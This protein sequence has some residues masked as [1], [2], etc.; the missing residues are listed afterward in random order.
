MKQVKIFFVCFLAIIGTFGMM[1]ATVWAAEK[2]RVVTIKD[3]KDSKEFYDDP[4]PWLTS[5]AF[6]YKKILPPD[7]HAKLSYDVEAMKTLW[8][9]VIGFKAP[10]V[11]HKIA[12]QIK[13]G[14]YSYKD[15]EQHPG[16]KAL[17]TEYHYNRFKP[18]APPFAGNFP[19]M[20][21]V[22]TKQY[23]YA[24]PIA[25]ATKKHM[26]QTMLDNQ[27]GLINEATY[28]AGLP[29]PRPEGKLKANQIYYNWLKRYFGWDNRYMLSEVRG[30]TGSLR[31]DISQGFLMWTLRLQGRVLEPYGWL[32]ERAQ[33][34]GEFQAYLSRYFAPRD[35]FG[36][37][38]N[39]ITYMAPDKYDQ[40]M[41]YVA[42]LRR[43][44]LMSSTDVQDAVAGGDAIYLDSD[45]CAQK[46]SQTIFPTKLELIAEKE[47]LF[48]TNH[49]GSAYLTSPD[50][51]LEYHNLKWER[52]PIYVIKMTIHD[53]N[54]V[55]GH[56]ILYI[57]KETFL[58]RLAENY[59]QNGRL[60]RTGE[61]M[62]TFHF[63]MGMP[64]F[65]DTLAQDHIDLHSSSSHNFNMPTPWIGRNDVG[66]EKLFTRGK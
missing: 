34:Q 58:L 15:K 65:G 11:V 16:L 7:V 59:D 50:K 26:G 61:I 57:D 41:L 10:D 24:I 1:T 33:A 32:D 39:F 55:Y 20:Q 56:R 28:V 48:P 40:V 25:E 23:Y 64:N 62:F 52:R 8:A 21:I 42:G 43:V 49:D 2:F 51:G 38:V 27:T 60:Y 63:D 45:L 66:F 29:F 13:P 54:F 46:I 37:Q 6:S 12:S 9:E 36:N 19:E 44:R 4:R 22:P 5:D 14:T 31:E 17:M 47:L 35:A 3:L 53:K 30:W 18:G